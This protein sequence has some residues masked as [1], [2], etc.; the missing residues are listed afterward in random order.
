MCMHAVVLL[1]HWDTACAVQL[2]ASHALGLG[3]G[4]DAAGNFLISTYP[5]LAIRDDN[6]RHLL[7][8]LLQRDFPLPSRGHCSDGGNAVW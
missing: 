3:H 6:L 8:A 7:E 2:A 4:H 5:H 1:V